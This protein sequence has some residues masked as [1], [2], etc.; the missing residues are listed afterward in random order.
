MFSFWI[1]LSGSYF[2]PFI[3]YFGI[4]GNVGNFQYDF[5]TVF[6]HEIL[7]G[8]GFDSL[9]YPQPNNNPTRLVNLNW[10]ASQMS[11]FDRLLYVTGSSDTPITTWTTPANA[12][13]QMALFN[14]FTSGRLVLRTD[15]GDISLFVIESKSLSLLFFGSSHSHPP[16]A[17]RLLN[18]SPVRLEFT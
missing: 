18:I 16:S 1:S 11:V 13:N 15:Y 9:L 14:A 7:H 5:A 2:S 17:M 12:A 10:P 6:M 4:D 8:I 3:G